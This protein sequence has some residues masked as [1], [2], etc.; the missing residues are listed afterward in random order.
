[1]EIVDAFEIGGIHRGYQVRDDAIH[2][3]LNFKKVAVV[4]SKAEAVGILNKL[5][6]SCPPEALSALEEFKEILFR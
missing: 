1:M 2:I 5:I 3:F 4:K 6:R